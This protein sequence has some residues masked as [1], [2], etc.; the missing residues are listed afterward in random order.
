LADLR[1]W[2]ES[3]DLSTLVPSLKTPEAVMA[4]LMSSP[5]A[6]SSLCA[7]A[8]PALWGH[9]PGSD[10]WGLTE[11]A[12]HLRDT[13][14]EIHQMQL[15]LLR[16]QTEPFIPRPDTSVWASQ[17]NYMNE[18]GPAALEQFTQ[19]RAQTIAALRDCSASDWN[20]KARH[21]IFGPTNVLE[22]VSFM[23]DHDRMH[24]QQAWKTV[25]AD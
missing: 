1:S 14:R 12:C 18:N 6:L 16:E 3:T 15:K 13:E 23:A 4:V 24:I 21:A 2:L 19:A 8:A 11:L 20:R 17:R 25:H 10:D 5:A 22:V 7:N 9:Q